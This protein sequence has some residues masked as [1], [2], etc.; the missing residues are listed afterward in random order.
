M[1][2]EFQQ[3][4][5]L[6]AASAN[7]TWQNLNIK[8]SNWAKIEKLAVEQTVQFLLGYSLKKMHDCS[9]P[10]EIK[11]RLI[12]QMRG[13]SMQNHACT[14][15][16]IKMLNE[17]DASGIHNVMFKGWTV[18]KY[19]AAP[20]ARVSADVDILVDWKDEKRAIEFLSKK[21]FE[22]KKRWDAT[23]CSLLS[24]DGI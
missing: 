11:Q 4:I 23:T 21:G 18:A 12:Q 19:Y 16:I 13:V 14:C 22:I 15:E 3:L 20:D 17:M 8:N 6:V 5:G 24:V 7:G 10:Q 2:K 1:T 9:C